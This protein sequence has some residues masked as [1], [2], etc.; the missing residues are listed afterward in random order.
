M[1]FALRPGKSIGRELKRLVRKELAGAVDRLL[2]VHP[3]DDEVHESRKSVKKVEALAKLL[4]QFGS[5]PPRKAVTRLREARRTLSKVRDADAMIE[6]SNRLHARFAP[7]IPQHTAAIIRTYLAGRKSTIMR[8]ART[9]TG[10]LARAGKT[11]RKVRRSTK[12]WS[13]PSIELSELPQVLRGSF[14][15]SRKAMMRAQTWRRSPDFH[16]WRKRVKHLWYQLRLAERLVLGLSTQIEEFGELETVLGEEH[17]L[18]VLRTKLRRNRS[19]RTIRSQIDRLTAMSTALQ[20]EL[21]RS[22]FVLGAR[23]YTMSPKEF[24][25]D[26]LRHLRPKGT[27]RRKPSPLTRGPAVVA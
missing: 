16:A 13:V 25:H 10:S 21:R 18:A 27:R 23:L 12:Q 4:D 20:E 24:E 1:A 6:T 17:N 8:R 22:A 5:A 7:Q 15:A 9:G 26:L 19:L 11:L 3:S 14:R 2:Q